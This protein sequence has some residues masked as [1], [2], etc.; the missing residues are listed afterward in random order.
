MAKKKDIIKKSQMIAIESAITGELETAKVTMIV[1]RDKPKYRE[2]FTILFQATTLAMGR[3]ITPSASKLLINLC[4]CV[5]YGNVIEKGID[6]LANHMKYSRRQ[7]ERAF[8]ELVGYNVVIA[9]K[10]PQD[11]RIT[12]YHLN[13][14]QSWKGSPNERKTRISKQ[15]EINPNQLD[16]F[17]V[18]PKKIAITPNKDFDI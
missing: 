1:A 17:E 4:G 3:E 15:R 16:I 5:G 9:S 10:H 13:A 6:E 7:I 18:L 8:K 2:P 12:Q 11:K 14:L